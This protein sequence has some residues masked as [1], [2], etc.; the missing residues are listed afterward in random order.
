MTGSE[1]LT[2]RKDVV[3]ITTGSKALDDLLGKKL[4]ILTNSKVEDWSQ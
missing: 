2:K 1:F 4:N 3:R